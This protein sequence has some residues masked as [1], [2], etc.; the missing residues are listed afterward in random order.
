MPKNFLTDCTDAQSTFCLNWY[1]AEVA[2]SKDAFENLKKTFE[3]SCAD[4]FY[5]RH[6]EIT[7]ETF[8]KMKREWKV[9]HEMEKKLV[10]V[11]DCLCAEHL[12]PTFEDFS[13]Y[14]AH[15]DAAFI[16]LGF[17]MKVWLLVR[18]CAAIWT[19]NFAKKVTFKTIRRDF[20]WDLN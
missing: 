6:L 2:A 7:S 14:I 17:W 20:L 8:S 5:C 9:T 18:L 12:C 15:F 13:S 16:L 10:V 19:K 3:R 11:I 4:V 1:F